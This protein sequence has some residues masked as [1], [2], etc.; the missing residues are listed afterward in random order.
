M[1]SARAQKSLSVR[2]HFGASPGDVEV[3]ESTLLAARYVEL[4]LAGSLS[5]P[6]ID[7]CQR[8][9]KYIRLDRGDAMGRRPS[10]VAIL[11]QA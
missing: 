4:F 1:D 3:L 8:Q 9:L 7:S 2:R 6:V 10:I 11:P 5:V